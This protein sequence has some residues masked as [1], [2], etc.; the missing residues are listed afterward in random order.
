MKVLIG[1]GVLAAIVCATVLA[2][3]RSAPSDGT[4]AALTDEVRLLRVAVEK[5]TQT[6]TQLQGLSVYLAAEQSRLVQTSARVDAIR[7]DLNAAARDSKALASRIA[8]VQANLATQATP[9][10][11]AQMQEM[12]TATIAEAA[13]ATEYETQLRARE[14]AA[15]TDLQNELAR[16]SDRIARLEQTIK[17]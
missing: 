13:R 2:Q 8:T 12:L 1:T 6:Q 5:S 4:L 9:E 3:E 16:W 14:A 7:K 15:S 17:Q 10:M 11:R